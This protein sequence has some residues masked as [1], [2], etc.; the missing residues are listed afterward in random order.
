LETVAK[1]A[2]F[3]FRSTSHPNVFKYYSV[4]AEYYHRNQSIQIIT[5]HNAQASIGVLPNPSQDFAKSQG[6]EVTSL[7]NSD[8][9]LKETEWD[10]VDWKHLAQNR[11][12]VNG[13]EPSSYTMCRNFLAYVMNYPRL[14]QGFAEWR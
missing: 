6:S 7:K 11:A 2:T 13:S 5:R 10:G 8:T 1:T 9:D 14:K 3:S 12:V 4:R